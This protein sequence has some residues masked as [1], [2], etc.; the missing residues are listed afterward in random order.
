MKDASLRLLKWIRSEKRLV[1]V[2]YS[3]L[4]FIILLPLLLP[5][6]ILT[7]DLVF[8]PNFAWPTELTNTYPLEMVLWIIHWILPGDVIE[9]II[10]F[11]ILLLSGVGMH[12]LVRY[13]NHEKNTPSNI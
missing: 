10:L 5:G 2:E 3:V 4:S 8:T 12:Q 1:W 6:Y 11:S 7:L 13:A 9:K